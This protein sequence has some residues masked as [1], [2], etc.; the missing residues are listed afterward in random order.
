MRHFHICCDGSFGNRLSGLIGGLTLAR[1]AGLQPKV[2]WLTQICV[3]LCSLT[4]L[5]N[6]PLK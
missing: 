1:L 6:L 5:L 2:S 3:V 4:S